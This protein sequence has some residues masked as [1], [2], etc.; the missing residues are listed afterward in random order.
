MVAVAIILALSAVRH[1]GSLQTFGYEKRRC[2]QA[3]L[4]KVGHINGK[5]SLSVRLR[6]IGLLPFP[7]Y[8][9]NTIGHYEFFPTVVPASTIRMKQKSRMIVELYARPEPANPSGRPESPISNTAGELPDDEPTLDFG[10]LIGSY[11]SREEAIAFI[12]QELESR[13]QTLVDTRSAPF[14]PYTH[15]EWLSV[16]V[17]TGNQPDEVRNYYLV[18]DE[19]Y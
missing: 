4:R 2:L 11:D 3:K 16:T 18:S 12:H 1:P 6:L 15:V 19:G 5:N 14:N 17:S 13:N 8:F 7:A 9:P 10:D